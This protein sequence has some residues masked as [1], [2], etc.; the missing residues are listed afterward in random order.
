VSVWACNYFK[1]Y[2]LGDEARRQTMWSV[3]SVGGFY[4]LKSRVTTTVRNS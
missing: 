3:M 1:R 2:T 4:P